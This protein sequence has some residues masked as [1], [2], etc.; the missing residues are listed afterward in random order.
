[1]PKAASKVSVITVCRNSEA[2]IEDTLQSV[3]IQTYPSVEHIVVDGGSSDS[4][5]KIVAR[6][7]H[8]ARA[9]S[10]RDHGIYDAMNKGIRLSTGEIIGT[11][12]AD[13]FYAEPDVLARVA[14]L[15]EDPTID[16]CYGDLCYVG[17]DDPTRIVRYW[18]S[19]EFKPDLFLHG[20]CPPHPTFFVR[21][22]VYD[23]L[24]TYDESY[25][26]AA[27][28]D[29]TMRYLE[30]HRVRSRYLPQV[31]VKM[32]MG[33]SSNKSIRNVILQNREI[34]AAL[35]KHGLEP[36]F[37][38]FAAGKLFSRGRQFLARST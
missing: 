17:Y 18:R 24:G 8:V 31:L 35:R 10:E 16:V 7:P 14:A 2:T 38:R 32:R 19:S 9:V 37:L 13:D 4:T 6:F 30:K 36:S 26:I 21:R 20:W 25:K 28:V 29:L 34:W 1:M 27:D 3:A 33:G 22:S 5:M 15:F 12:N 11:I 23:R